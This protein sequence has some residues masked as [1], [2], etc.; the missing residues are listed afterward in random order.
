MLFLGLSS[1]NFKKSNVVY[2]SYKN[3]KTLA[4]YLAFNGDADDRSNSNF[5]NKLGNVSY[6]M[7]RFGNNKS[8]AV[9]LK[10]D[11]LSYGD[12]LDN[13]FSG[14]QKRF[15]VSFWVKPL[16][17]KGNVIIICKNSDPN[18]EENERQFSINS[19]KDNRIQFLWNYNNS[20]YKGYRTFESEDKL[21]ENVWQNVI[22]T[23]DGVSYGDDGASRL[24]FYLNGTKTKTRFVEK[25]GLLGF[26][27]DK[28]AH[29]AIGTMVS[30]VGD[31][32]I[33]SFFNGSLDDLMIF[34]RILTKNEIEQISSL[35]N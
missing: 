16:K 12:I 31:T 17:N 2:D 1:C 3:D 11:Y 7:D 14:E 30:S 20:Q 29:F 26:I 21:I 9:F 24:S 23:F 4:L 28:K 22:I 10:N 19:S 6:K 34:Q 25:M 13:V 32:C 33:D 5:Q 15:T 8:A 35:K 18:C 27:E